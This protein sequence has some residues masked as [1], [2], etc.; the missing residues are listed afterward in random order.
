MLCLKL[1]YQMVDVHIL[2][3]RTLLKPL[4]EMVGLS[5]SLER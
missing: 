3:N 2:L 1:Y 5:L 4:Q